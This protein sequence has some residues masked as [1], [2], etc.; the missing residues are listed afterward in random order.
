MKPDKVDADQ[1]YLMLSMLFFILG[2]EHFNQT[3]L[4]FLYR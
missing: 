4:S 3:N 2:T 1:A